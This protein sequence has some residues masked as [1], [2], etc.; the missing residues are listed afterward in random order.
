MQGCYIG[1]CICSLSIVLIANEYN[2]SRNYLESMTCNRNKLGICATN[3]RCERSGRVVLSN[4]SFDLSTGDCLLLHGPNG[5]GKTTLLMTLAGIRKIVSGN[6]DIPAHEIA[7]HGHRN[8]IKEKLTIEE[9][10]YFW[11]MVYGEKYNPD[12]LELLDLTHLRCKRAEY[13]SAGEHKRLSLTVMMASKRNI[14][15]ADEPTSTLDQKSRD[16][17][18]EIMHNHCLNGGIIVHSSHNI[19]LGQSMLTLDLSEYSG[20][21]QYNNEPG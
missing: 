14:W 1:Y 4:L 20:V 16:K 2:I 7:F 10:L 12:I 8:A 11:T 18:T 17:F 6:L 3:I 9:N 21:Y 15:L 5:I 19:D 13:L